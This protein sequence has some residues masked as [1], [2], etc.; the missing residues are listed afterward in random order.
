MTKISI[1]MATYNGESFIRRQLDSIAQQTVPPDELIV[2]DD[3]S[4][5][6][7]MSIVNDF[8]RSA[9]FP[10]VV[11]K[12]AKRLGFTANFLQA[13][14]MCQGDLIA[15][16][17]QD[18]E[19]LPQKLRRILEI[20]RESD[21]LL[22]A[23]ADELIDRNGDSMGIFC[24]I[25]RPYRKFIR[26]N[27]F[28]GHAIVVRSDLLEMTSNSLTPSNYKELAGDAEIG[29]DV[30]LI[31][32]ADAMS[33]LHFAPDVLVRWRF[34]SGPDHAPPSLTGPPRRPW[35]SFSDWLYP[36]DLVQGYSSAALFHRRHSI[37]LACVLRE[38]ALLGR[39]TAAARAKLTL[40]MNL[41]ARKADVL[42]LRAAFYGPLSRKARIK[43]MLEGAAKGQ[44]R[45]TKQGG[46][47]MHNAV[48]DLIACLF[49]VN[50]SQRR[51]PFG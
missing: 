43:L 38:L 49:N 40:S 30:L 28:P 25:D 12:N 45:N 13:A 29:H 16:C 31:E 9:P 1:A 37:L 41:L 24:P 3:G 44:Y 20:S 8:S 22:F 17:D 39:D 33:K 15:F 35:V 50:R 10:V 6:S 32:I 14:R 42:E 21:A 2:C 51:M 36:P 7:T 23:H 46:V 19:W 48:R 5:D 26:L 4:T 27:D 11:A 34:Y 47:R 18:D